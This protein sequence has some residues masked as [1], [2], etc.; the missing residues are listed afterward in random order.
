MCPMRF[1]CER[2]LSACTL[3]Q[4]WWFSS[5]ALLHAAAA[6]W[7]IKGR[8]PCH[9]VLTRHMPVI[10]PSWE[11]GGGGRLQCETVFRTPFSLSSLP[12]P[13]PQFPPW[14]KEKQT[15]GSLGNP[16]PTLKYDMAPPY[17]MIIIFCIIGDRNTRVT[18]EHGFSSYRKERG[19]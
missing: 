15:W 7:E 18:T 1:Y 14:V 3:A 11:A 19:Y 2:S 6:K 16:T 9:F 8:V 5:T 17:H 4:P 13:Q 10:L 12:D